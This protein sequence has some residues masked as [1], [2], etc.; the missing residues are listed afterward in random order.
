VI[1]RARL[2]AT[3]LA[4]LLLWPAALRAEGELA[5]FAYRQRPGSEVPLDAVLRDERGRT[6]RLGTLLGGRPAILAL[7]YF[8]CPNLCGV[9]RADLIDALARSGLAPADYALIVL[10][11]DPDETAADAARAHRED[12]ARMPAPEGAANWHY[13]TG[14]AEP[15]TAVEEAVGF[16]AR[17]D[18]ALRQFLH[19]AGLVVLTAQGAVSSY[20]L[21]VGYRP[22]DLRAAVTR[23]RD[24]GVAKAVLP[25]LL[26]C[27]H[28][29]PV[30]GRYT[31][32]VTR[33][34]QLAGGLTVLTLGGTIVLALRR[35]RR[36]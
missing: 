34:L 6:A 8:H 16:R 19:P 27:F 36:R 1:A 24:G 18:P 32:A 7:S 5:Q 25:V 11:I 3:M 20:L 22:G 4:T 35:E 33:L 13:L 26:L 31:L 17:Y 15:L 28:Y 12:A 14:G 21:G 10:S 29:D 2:V 30:T 23:A 9:V